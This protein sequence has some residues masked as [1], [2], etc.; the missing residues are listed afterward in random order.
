MVNQSF[1]GFS[2]SVGVTLFL[3]PQPV[4]V[5]NRGVWLGHNGITGKLLT[6][7]TAGDPLLQN[8]VTGVAVAS[9]MFFHTTLT[10]A[11]YV[12]RARATVKSALAQ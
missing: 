12:G 4:L 5:E 2:L 9:C 3:P 8:A 1:I 6:G 11:L 10:A 7:A